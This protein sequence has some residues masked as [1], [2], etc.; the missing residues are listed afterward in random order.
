MKYNY[1]AE[2]IRKY[3]KRAN[4]TQQQLADKVGISWEMISRYERSESSPLKK[5]LPLSSALKVSQSQ[6][7]EKHVPQRYHQLEC[8][9]PLFLHPP[10]SNRFDAN[11]TN[12]FYICPEWIIKRDVQS[13]AIDSSLISRSI[14]DFKKGGIVYISTKCSP[15]K[16]DLILLKED[17]N[18]II[19]K[20]Q[21]NRNLNILGKVLAQEIRY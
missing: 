15:Q 21:G 14:E 13:I 2:N 1:I 6:L 9:V 11:Q 17:C 7:L 20:Y 4:L 10:F 19:D 5:L 18:L 3:R 12:Y 8:K 16:N